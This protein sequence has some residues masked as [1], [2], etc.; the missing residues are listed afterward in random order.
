MTTIIGYTYDAGVH[1]PTCTA[2]RA[3]VG[4]LTREAP[5]FLWPDEHGLA[6]DLVDREGN[7]IHPLFITDEGAMNEACEDCGKFLMADCGGCESWHPQGFDGDCR[8]DK[9]RR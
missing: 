9:N 6:Q 2:N 5:L 8:D 3:D 1:C 4:L 7:P